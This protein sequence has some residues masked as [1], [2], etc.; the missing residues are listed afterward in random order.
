MTLWITGAPNQRSGKLKRVSCAELM[1]AKQ[2]L[3]Q[4]TQA[5]TGLNGIPIL[6]QVIQPSE[7]LLAI[8]H[9]KISFANQA[10]E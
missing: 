9:R 3:G 5:I 6:A 1:F 2:M 10:I 7:S 4:V 8:Q